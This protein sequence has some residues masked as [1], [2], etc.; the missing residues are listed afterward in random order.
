MKCK[1]WIIGN[2]RYQSRSEL[3]IV[4]AHRD[5][6]RVVDYV[7]VSQTLV[8]DALGQL[9]SLLSIMEKTIP[10]HGV[11]QSCGSV[12]D[13]TLEKPRPFLPVCV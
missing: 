1:Y 13:A 4:E 6:Y 3:R 10:N 2:Q 12:I 9:Q 5:H 11:C 8:R 7:G